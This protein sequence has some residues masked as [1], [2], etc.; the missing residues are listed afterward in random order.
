MMVYMVPLIQPLRHWLLGVV[1]I[2]KDSLTAL[3]NAVITHTSEC[4]FQERRKLGIKG[5]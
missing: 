4:S 3:E 1:F 2:G 5:G